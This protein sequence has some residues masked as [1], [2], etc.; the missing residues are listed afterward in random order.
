[1]K[2]KQLNQLAS[3]LVGDG[4]KANVFFVTQKGDVV[5]VTT[6]FSAAYRY[7]NNLAGQRIE[8]ALEDR[9][10]GV[11]CS[12]GMEPSYSDKTDDFTGPNRWE[13]R[14]DTRMFGFKVL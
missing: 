3:E 13:H 10:T 2:V 1:M 8:S 6:D 5:L 11:I 14:D 12:A 7:W 4:K 9:Q